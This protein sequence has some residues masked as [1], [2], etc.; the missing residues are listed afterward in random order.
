MNKCIVCVCVSECVSEGVVFSGYL[1]NINTIIELSDIQRYEDCGIL[2]FKMAG[3]S[4]A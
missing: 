2:E 3:H 4:H 1:C